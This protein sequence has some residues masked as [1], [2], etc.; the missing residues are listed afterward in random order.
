MFK[1]NKHT[2]YYEYPPPKNNVT[3]SLGAIR[4]SNIELLRV[5][6]MFMILFL[7]AN[8]LSF[9]TPNLTNDGYIGCGLRTIAE[10]LCNVAVDVYVLISGFFGI[11]FKRKGLLSLLYQVTFFS[12]IV[13][14]VNIILGNHDITMFSE[15]LIPGSAYWFVVSY[16]GLYILSPVLNTFVESVSKKTF[17]DI[18]C[19]YLAFVY[20]YGFIMGKGSFTGG[21]S[22][23][24][25]IALYMIARY[26]RLYP[27]R[28]TSFNKSTDLGIY[29]II[30]SLIAVLL[31]AIT[32]LTPGVLLSVQGRLLAYHN[33]LT[34][35]AAVYFLLFFSKLEFTSKTVNFI[36]AS[37]FAVYLLHCNDH[38]ISYYK[39][40]L[41]HIVD[42]LQPAP[43]FVS[44]LF[45]AIAV[46][47]LA[48][49]LDQIRIITWEKINKI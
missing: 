10:S 1:R 6:L 27:N 45:Y 13:L 24:S 30:S 48:I 34:M 23:L 49:A 11:K 21:Y 14:I 47:S 31:Y 35:I 38:S 39:K 20:I 15:Q 25:F 19:T 22:L 44:V 28:F 3:T 2:N 33:P 4:K 29:L 26:V 8:Y 12:L 40:G 18:L 16:I 7:H 17:R 37:S 43:A 42:Y 46:Y 36:A 5:V 41:I 9:D 32:I